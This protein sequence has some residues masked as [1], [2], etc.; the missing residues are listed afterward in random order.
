MNE[1]CLTE[2]FFQMKKFLVEN[3]KKAEKM[4]YL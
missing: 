2:G 4:I 1:N 3:L